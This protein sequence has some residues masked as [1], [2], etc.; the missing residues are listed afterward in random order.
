[1][2]VTGERPVG[3][4]SARLAN[5]QVVVHGA[6]HRGLELFNGPAL[7]VDLIPE[8]DHVPRER[9]RLGV[10]FDHSRVALVLDHDTLVLS[11]G[12]EVPEVIEVHPYPLDQATPTFL[13][14][15]RPIHRELP[16]F[17]N[18]RDRGTGTFIDLRSEFLEESLDPLP[19]QAAVQPP[20]LVERVLV[21]AHGT[22]I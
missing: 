21:P 10:E 17:E 14:R 6:T 18:E 9:R 1:M 13:A 2:E 8:V 19:V 3:L 22:K 4:L 7:E 15:V 12:S 16:A 5:T 11:G 20:N